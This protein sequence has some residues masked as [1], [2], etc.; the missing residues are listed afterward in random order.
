MTPPVPGVVTEYITTVAVL[1][2]VLSP[3]VLRRSTC[4]GDGEYHHTHDAVGHHGGGLFT[5]G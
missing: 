2:L 5:N 1:L 4:I 3:G